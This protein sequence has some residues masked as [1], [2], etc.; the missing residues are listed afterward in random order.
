M[1]YRRESIC[2]RAEATAAAATAEWASGGPHMGG[3]VDTA[4]VSGCEDG[5]EARRGYTQTGSIN[6][7]R[8]VCAT[9]S[10]C[11]RTAA[12]APQHV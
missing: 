6:G 7:D 11:R 5:C 2:G 10:S 1:V 12:G 8:R 4:V 9:F 3:R